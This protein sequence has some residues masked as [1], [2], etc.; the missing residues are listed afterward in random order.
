LEIE[1][2]F[3][4]KNL[5]KAELLALL[6]KIREWELSNPRTELDGFTYKTEP[7]MSMAESAELFK[8]ISPQFKEVLELV[9]PQDSLLSL[10]AR[11]LIVNGEILGSVTELVLDLGG[12]D[13]E[14]IKKLREAHKIVLQ[15]MGTG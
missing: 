10:G 5:S 3:K 14:S 4:A 2:T 9:L 6:Q 1:M 15:R 13:P 12:A 8:G 7:M 11:S